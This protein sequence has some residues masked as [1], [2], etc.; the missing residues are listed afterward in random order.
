M[1]VIPHL[2]DNRTATFPSI[3]PIDLRPTAPNIRHR[4]KLLRQRALHITQT[5]RCGIARRDPGLLEPVPCGKG[6]VVADG[7][8]EK[9]D[10]VFV[11]D[12]LW[13]VARGVEG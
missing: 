13:T 8:L 3:R 9:V 1:I 10:H 6:Q 7:C 4:A 5:I 11:G 12:V 2:V